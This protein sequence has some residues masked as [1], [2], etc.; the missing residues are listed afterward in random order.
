MFRG[1]RDLI[2]VEMILEVG[3]EGGGSARM[4]G[5]TRGLV[6]FCEGVTVEETLQ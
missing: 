4:V 1:E 3:F 2:V 6:I 5:T